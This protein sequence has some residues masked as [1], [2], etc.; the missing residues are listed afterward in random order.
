MPYERKMSPKE[1]ES[2]W[3]QERAVSRG[4]PYALKFTFTPP[5]CGT[6]KES[7]AK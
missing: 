4:P 2:L 7:R 1:S 6:G 3:E 5:H